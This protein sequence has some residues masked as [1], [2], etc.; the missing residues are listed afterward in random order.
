MVEPHGLLVQ[1]PVWYLLTRLP[2]RGERRMFRMDRM[3]EPSLAAASFVPSR[4][5]VQ[6][7]ADEIAA[8]HGKTTPDPR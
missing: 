6:A 3:R 2:G 1:P 7:F 4:E 8:I 5:V